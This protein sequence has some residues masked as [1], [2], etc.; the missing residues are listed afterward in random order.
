MTVNYRDEEEELGSAAVPYPCQRVIIQ[1]L[2]ISLIIVCFN[3]QNNFQ[4][5]QS[6]NDFK[7][8]C[9]LPNRKLNF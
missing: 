7:K 9:T 6:Y 1:Y 3:S 4:I 8:Y 2:E 5:K